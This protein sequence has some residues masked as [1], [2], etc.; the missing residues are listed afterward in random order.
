MKQY[1]TNNSLEQ[2]LKDIGFKTVEIQEKNQ[3]ICV[4][5]EK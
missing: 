2:L 3:C 5:A 4:I 1:N